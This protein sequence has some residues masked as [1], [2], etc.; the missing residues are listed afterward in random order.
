MVPTWTPTC[1]RTGCGHRR[2]SSS[3]RRASCTS[4]PPTWKASHRCMFSTSTWAPGGLAHNFG[5]GDVDA[6]GYADLWAAQ[7]VL[8]RLGRRLHARP[9]TARVPVP[10]SIGPRHFAVP[11]RPRERDR[12][13]YGSAGLRRPP[14]RPVRDDDGDLLGVSVEPGDFNGDGLVDVAVVGATGAPGLPRRWRGRGPQSSIGRSPTGPPALDPFDCRDARLAV[15]D[16]DRD[17]V[18]DFSINCPS[19]P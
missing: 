11:G 3:V 15:A 13:F 10:R 14:F 16:F 4:G 12:R 2:K 5:A 6:D 9:R 19:K 1:R 7:S 8:V 17:G 18:D